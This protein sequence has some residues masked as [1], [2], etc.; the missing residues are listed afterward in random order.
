MNTKWIKS[1]KSLNSESL[2]KMLNNLNEGIHVVD[3][4]GTTILYN[5]KASEIDGLQPEEVIGKNLF[6]VFPSLTLETSTL[7]KT[8]KNEEKHLNHRQ[9]FINYRGNKIT[10]INHTFP[11][12]FADD[13][14]GAVEISKDIT[15]TE[16]LV[17][18]IT[19]L[20]NKLKDNSNSTE[21][22]KEVDNNTSFEFAD[23]I[24]Q[25][26]KFNSSVSDAM[27]CARSDSSVLIYGETGTGKELFAQ[28]IH[29]A[30]RRKNQ[31]FIAQN[32]AALPKDLLE[33][34]LFGT[35]K[36]SFTGAKSKPGLFEMA[37][38]GTILLDEINSM[39]LALQAKLL[40]VL[41]DGRIRRIGGQK[42]KEVDVRIITTMN[43]HPDKAF[44]EN[45]LREDLYY[46]LSVV[47]I[48]LPPL[49]ERKDDIM[50]LTKNFI[51][52][53]N[54]KFN[55]DIKGL[56]PELKKIFKNY[57]WPGNVRELKHVIESAYNI[58]QYG[59]KIDIGDLPGYII[60]R[61]DHDRNINK[62]KNDF[63]E[64]KVENTS[65]LPSLDQYLEDIELNLIESA[66]EKT[67]NNISAA[68]RKLDISRQSLQ[69]KI[70]KYNIKDN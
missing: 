59:D 39:D 67:N 35:E 17:D 63:R 30:S 27:K 32:C 55:K 53:Y 54:Q 36:G 10:T 41:Q 18:D 40:R 5:K 31:E 64:H 52:H 49:R 44:E 28:S 15:Q 11:I 51:K 68:A 61:L 70:K 24:G 25:N 45:K 23:I 42:E 19:N 33:S 46:R 21:S 1:E 34:L 4:K 7:M 65:E 48:Y 12:K 2:C 13:S 29:N 47:Y 8:L 69:Y 38:G 22:K 62:D 60:E 57:S 9:T 16:E 3:N 43:M 58:K 56:E 37:D 20:R 14:K 26:P 50:L 66:L 6:E